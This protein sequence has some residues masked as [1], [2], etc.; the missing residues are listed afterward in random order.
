MVERRLKSNFG[1]YETIFFLFSFTLTIFLLGKY[2]ETGDTVPAETLPISLIKEHDLDFDEFVA[3]KGYG[4][5]FIDRNGTAVSRYPIVPGILNTPVYLVAY[6]I[7]IDP[8]NK[9]HELSHITASIIAALSV[10][11]MYLFLVRICK[12]KKTAI[13]F[14]LI[15]AFATC[16]W[17]VASTVLWQHG[18]SLLF[19]NIS[20]ALLIRPEKNLPGYAGF[21]LGMTVFNRPTNIVI[22]LPL[23]AYVFFHQKKQFGK[24]VFF[25]AIPAILLFWYSYAY[26]GSVTALGQG[27]GAPSEFKTPFLD[28]LTGILVSPNRGI[29]VFSSFFIFGIAYMVFSLISN[30]TEPIDRYLAIAAIL[31]LVVY[32]KWSMWW[33][34]WSFGYRII[35]EITPI[36]IIF[37]VRYWENKA[38]GQKLL[39]VAFLILVFL[40][41]YIHFLGAHYYQCGFNYEP[42]NS[43]DHPERMWDIKDGELMRCTRNFW[44]DIVEDF[45]ALYKDKSVL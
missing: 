8:V 21:F 31:L 44:A 22:A 3:T 32:A 35:T 38:V 23:A 26:L 6:S 33:G 9:E 17:S 41:V 25:A 39:K 11:F 19:I 24:F 28:G 13:M 37:T 14:S 30:K 16:V 20:L 29:L 18:P 36:L 7:G 10:V 43:D 45:K 42:N 27:Q 15:Y 12:R 34:G 2:P 5:W 4:Y 1:H 40:S